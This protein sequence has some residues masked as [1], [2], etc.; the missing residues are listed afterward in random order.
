[1]GTEA[2]LEHIRKAKSMVDVPIIASLNGTTLGG[3]VD[4]ARQIQ[5]GRGR[6]PR[7]QHLLDSHRHG[8]VRGRCGAAYLDI[9]K[10]VR[11]GGAN[12]PGGEAQP[13]LQQHRQHGQAPLRRQ[14]PDGL[15]LFNRFYQP[16]IDIEELEIQPNLMLSGPRIFACP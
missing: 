2:Y 11:G 10:A 3:W 16:D 7:T 6:C 1:V 8:P 13:L 4:Y 15:V 5:A 14:G 12:S 9:L